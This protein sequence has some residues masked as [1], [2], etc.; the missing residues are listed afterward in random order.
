MI[1]QSEAA[2]CGLAC[3]AMVANHHGHQLDLTTLRNRY[4]VSLKGANL[5]QLMQLANQLGL[6]PRAL[7]LDLDD[8]KNL[9]TPCILHWEMN[10]FVV[11]KKVHRK[12]ITILDP[13]LGER[14]VSLADVD[15]AFTGVALEL[16][17]STEFK[18]IDERVRLG[19]IAFWSK[20]QGLVPSLTKLFILSLLLQVF[21]LAAPYYTQLVVDEVL[22][23][24][25]KPLL[26]VLALG[27]GLLMLLQVLTQTLRGWVVLHLGSVMS[28]QM[29]ANL[30]RHL[31]HLPLSFFEKRHMGDVVSR[32]G[33]L[34]AVRELLTNSLVEGVIDGIMA[35]TVL[36]MMYLYSPQ[37]SLVVG[38]AV[39]L[40]GLLRWA[41]Y[42]PLHQL[43]EASIVASAKA[44][45]NFM[46]TVRG[47]QSIKLFG[48]QT[49]RLNIWQNRF[50]DA[51]N[52]NYRL[53]K[54]QISYGTINQLLFGIENILVVYLAALT[55][56]TGE[57]SV[58]MLFAFM[59][60]KNQFTNRTA[61]L[62]DK[63]VDIK[64]TRLHLDRLADIALTEKEDEGSASDS[65]VLSGQLS[66]T[67]IRFRYASNDPLLFNDLT[68]NVQAGE[69]I[70]IIGPSGTG[71]TSLMKIM[72]GLLPAES[73]K[74]EV[75]G[76]DIRH[77]GLRHYRSQIAAVMQDDQLMSGTL[78]ENISF[79][80]PVCQLE[81]VYAAAQ[82]AGIHQD[83]LAM[84]MGYNSLVGDMG[85]SLS[86]GQ[87]QRILLARALYRQPK[88]LF[89]D[90]ATSH[91]D[92][93]LEQHVNQAV[94][95]LKM[96]R[97]IIAHRPQTIAAAER[98][99][100]LKQG[101]LTDITQ[102]YRAQLEQ[103]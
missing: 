82:L 5:Q 1:Y 6:T 93:Q 63:V 99:L 84:P 21:V 101:Q 19:L 3:M 35:I 37:L 22:I 62:I 80:D 13:A 53:G 58:G 97:I 30:M 45:S 65:R 46:E 40:Y 20:M 69:N 83:I 8:L 91:L 47:M 14:R 79:F 96:T 98:I 25:D 103:K 11:L 28:V 4:S 43:T 2:E 78:A 44:Q 15:K 34:N 90:E 77:L 72:L 94:Q 87:K 7:K 86:G 41:L 57:M 29:A 27:F 68:L 52:Q 71:K 56:M 16:T 64:M 100:L 61:A 31:V 95:Q 55:V 26:V 102:A 23:S 81:Q 48:L 59:A 50:A 54:W 88:I 39:L 74:V 33:S 89:L 42:R 76:I 38:I 36:V 70:A 85:S 51:V 24:Q 49:Q 66:L 32:F 75:D 60:Y 67:A 73:G 18:K 17:P 12:G 92:L 9:R 10:H